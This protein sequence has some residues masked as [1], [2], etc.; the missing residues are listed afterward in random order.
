MNRSFEL[1]PAVANLAWE[2]ILFLRHSAMKK[3]AAT[4]AMAI[5]LAI[6]VNTAQAADYEAQV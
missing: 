2:H 4:S 1:Q 3:I 6:S 5:A